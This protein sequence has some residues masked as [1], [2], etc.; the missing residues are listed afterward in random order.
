MCLSQSIANFQKHKVPRNSW[1]WRRL[2]ERFNYILYSLLLGLEQYQHFSCPGD[3]FP[4]SRWG[5]SPAVLTPEASLKIQEFMP[6]FG[7]LSWAC[8]LRYCPHWSWDTIRLKSAFRDSDMIGA[9]GVWVESGSMWET[10]WFCNKYV[11]V[12]LLRL[13]IISRF[14]KQLS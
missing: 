1:A 2:R 14:T 12:F 11:G 3:R 9:G 7:R 8:H 4:S 10:G 13:D 5:W 6:R